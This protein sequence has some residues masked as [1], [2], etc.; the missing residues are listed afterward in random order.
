[1]TN[2]VMFMVVVVVT[3]T[4]RAFPLDSPPEIEEI[5]DRA[6]QPEG[7]V[8]VV[9]VNLTRLV[10]EPHKQGMIKISYWYLKSMTSTTIFFIL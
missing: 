9:A 2:M 6:R 5:V 1:M 8:G 10:Q 7:A 4:R 3:M